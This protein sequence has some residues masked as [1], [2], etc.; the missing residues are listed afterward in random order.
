MSKDHGS[1]AFADPFAQANPGTPAPAHSTGLRLEPKLALGQRYLKT[2]RYQKSQ[3]RAR[4]NRVN[5]PL[6]IDSN[7]EFASGVHEICRKVIDATFHW[8][9]CALLFVQMSLEESLSSV[10]WQAVLVRARQACVTG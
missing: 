8:I 4:L 10:L 6:S 2:V 5:T 9:A 7:P 3:E 1:W